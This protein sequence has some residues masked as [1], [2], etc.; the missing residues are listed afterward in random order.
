[1]LRSVWTE[2]QASLIIRDLT[3]RIFAITR[4]REKKS[5]RK[6][7]TNFA[8]IVYDGGMTVWRVHQLVTSHQYQCEREC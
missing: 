3:L 7:Y 8:V 6:L 4:F 2:L 5:V 1:M